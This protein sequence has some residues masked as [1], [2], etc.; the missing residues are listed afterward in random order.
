MIYGD[1][2]FYYVD[3]MASFS[4]NPGYSLSGSDSSICKTAG[5]GTWEHPTPTCILGEEWFYYMQVEN[6]FI[7]LE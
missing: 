3:T 7:G 2:E 6:C 1:V 4:C 5:G